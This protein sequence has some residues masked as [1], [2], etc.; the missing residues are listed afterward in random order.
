M[1]SNRDSPIRQHS[2]IGSRLRQKKWVVREATFG[3]GP[4]QVLKYLARYTHRVAISNQRLIAMEEGKVSFRWKDYADGNQPKTMELEA[5]EFIRRFLQH[6]VPSGFVR[7]RHY[8]FLANRHRD[9]KLLRCRELLAVA[10]V[11]PE[12]LAP[13]EPKHPEPE[14]AVAMPEWQRCSSCR[15]GRMTWVEDISPANAVAAPNGE[16]L[17]RATARTCDSS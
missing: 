5:V 11:P 9:A 15:Q 4:E 8:G 14:P 1:V 10:T 2:G 6:V 13:T 7:I 17:A 12:K 16:E 3:S